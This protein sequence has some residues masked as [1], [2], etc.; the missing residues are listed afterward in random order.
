MMTNGK[1]YEQQSRRNQVLIASLEAMLER[2]QRGEL[3]NAI[4]VA[5]GAGGVVEHAC[6]VPD[7]D[8]IPRLVGELAIMGQALRTIVVNQRAEAAQRE[9]LRRPH[10]IG[11]G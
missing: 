9:A 8:E 5:I 2:A 3:V 7:G 1:G 4:M 11:P 6:C 10:I